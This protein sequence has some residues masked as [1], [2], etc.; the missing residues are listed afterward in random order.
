MKFR[1]R[2]F[3]PSIATVMFSSAAICFSDDSVAIICVDESELRIFY[4]KYKIPIMSPAAKELSF[5]QD[6]Q[7]GRMLEESGGIEVIS[8][9]S[10]YIYYYFFLIYLPILPIL[11]M[12]GECQ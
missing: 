10:L 2:F 8:T 9:P 11:P 3:C 12:N 5:G 4:G 6:G 7:V 1:T